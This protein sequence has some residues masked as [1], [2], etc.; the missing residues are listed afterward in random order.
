MTLDINGSVILRDV[1]FKLQPGD[2]CLVLGANGAGAPDSL[3]AGIRRACVYVS[4][5]Q[6]CGW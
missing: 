6:P 5:M 1:S 3:V 2:R 4:R